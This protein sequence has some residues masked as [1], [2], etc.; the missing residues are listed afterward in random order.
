MLPPQITSPTS[1]RDSAEVV[2]I[3]A[4]PLPQQPSATSFAERATEHRIRD[5]ASV[6]VSMRVTCRLMIAIQ[7]LGALIWR[8]LRRVAPAKCQCRELGLYR[9]KD[10]VRADDWDRSGLTIWRQQPCPHWPRHRQPALIERHQRSGRSSSIF[11]RRRS[12]P[13]RADRIIEGG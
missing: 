12:A 5:R 1:Y 7:R 2:L 11:Q 9:V 4:K 8:C 3:T 10:R 13:W 6:A